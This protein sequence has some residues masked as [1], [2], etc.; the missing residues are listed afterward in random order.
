MTALDEG[1]VTSCFVS[2][3]L[4]IHLKILNIYYTYILLVDSFDVWMLILE[5]SVSFSVFLQKLQ[6]NTD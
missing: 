1:S 3:F 2:F 5:T 4:F 6:K